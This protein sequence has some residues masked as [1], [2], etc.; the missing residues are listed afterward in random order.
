[1]ARAVDN[2]ATALERAQGVELVEPRVRGKASG[3][4]GR[5]TGW[6]V[7]GVVAWVTWD[8]GGGRKRIGVGNLEAI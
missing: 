4:T 6:Y 5:V 1:M 3:R 8:N 7:P 2:I